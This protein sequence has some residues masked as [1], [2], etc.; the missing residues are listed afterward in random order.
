MVASIMLP[1]A[2]ILALLSATAIASNEIVRSEKATFRVET[3][4]T[5]L[6]HPWAL[7]KL[8][9]GRFLV[10]ERPGRLRLFEPGKKLSAP[11]ANVPAVWAQGQGGLLDVVL[12]PDFDRNRW[13]YLSFSKPIGKGAHTSVVRARL[14]NDRLEQVETIFDP[15]ASEATNNGAHF[16]SRLVFDGAGHLFLSIGDRGGPTTP[17]NKA[18]SLSSVIGKILRL[19]E[20]GSVP[21]DNPFVS[22]PAARPEIW[23]YGHRNIQG[24]LLD[25]SNSRLWA[26][27]HGPRG[28]D[29]LNLVLPGAN[30]GW[31]LVTHGINYNRTPI[32]KH[33]SAPGIE[34]PAVD[35]TPSIAP[36]GL[37]LYEGSAFPAWRG[38]L[39]AGALAHQ[40]LVRIEMDGSKASNQE[41]LLEGLGRI[42]DVRVF[43]DGFV[44]L[45]YDRP[46]QVVRLVP[47]L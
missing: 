25:K 11:L 38:N 10:T 26:T 45:V 33:S 34:S 37:A 46:G 22:K 23:S 39:L 28:G 16:G 15:P 24:M 36:S 32:T 18:Q 17:A 27:E 19:R 12:H 7:A 5:G 8:P 47:A 29:E 14:E 41:I 1:L 4:A 30:Y 31:A 21:P 42:R 20:D 40:K 2:A 13:I 44:Y 6:E 43:D 9:D 35:W 3:L